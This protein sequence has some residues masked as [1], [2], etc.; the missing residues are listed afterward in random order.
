MDK[1]C[2]EKVIAGAKVRIVVA[3]V[4]GDG[5]PDVALYVNGL[6]IGK[7]P[8]AKLAGNIRAEVRRALKKFRKARA[9][10]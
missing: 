7:V 9:R 1:L 4:D 3:D 10:A 8:L 2:V 5:E 6:R